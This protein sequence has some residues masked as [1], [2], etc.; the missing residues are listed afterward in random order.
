M[1]CVFC[2]LF[3]IIIFAISM[4]GSPEREQE[5]NSY[6]QPTLSGLEA[7][8][9]QEELLERVTIEAV[10]TWKQRQV[11]SEWHC[12]VY[13]PPDIFHQERNDH[14]ELH[15]R[16]YAKAA[17]RLNLLPGDTVTLTGTPYTQEITTNDGRTKIIKHFTVSRIDVVSRAKRMSITVY[18]RKRGR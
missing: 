14:Y 17:K 12:R 3:A 6:T 18:E 10:P 11:G 15:T 9:S 1:D 5:Q 2:T 16:S 8:G 4:A 7:E 13:T